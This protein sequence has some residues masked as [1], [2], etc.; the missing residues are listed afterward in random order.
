M[1]NRHPAATPGPPAGLRDLLRPN[2]FSTALLEKDRQ[3]DFWRELLSPLVDVTP[4]KPA[5]NGFKASGRSFDL[6]VVQVAAVKSEPMRFARSGAHAH[7]A[8]KY[9]CL[10]VLK[11]GT[12][13]N[14]VG[15]VR[16]EV[17]P[18]KI[19]IN[20]L[21]GAF[22]GR[23][24]RIECINLLL[25]RDFFFDME[26][27]ID[28]LINVRL[29]GPAARILSEFVLTSEKFFPALTISE[30][31]LWI[32][33]FSLLLGAVLRQQRD[34]RSSVPVSRDRASSVLDYIRENLHSQTLGARSICQALKI[35]RRQLYYLL[36]PYGGVAGLITR[37]RLV[38]VCRAL[39]RSSEC[40]L[41]STVAYSL[42]FS[43]YAV[44]CKQFRE[45]FGF[46]P[47]D[48]RDASICGYLPKKT[49]P[50]SLSQLLSDGTERQ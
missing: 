48:A 22:S 37:K 36:A 41:I 38:A 35:S 2:R 21:A 7:P 15:D 30:T 39:A 17:V 16:V 31:S 1:S 18:G 14:R 23:T 29:E 34:T 32:E 26:A 19:L 13:V 46:S 3:F 27:D 45:E 43:D 24:D 28:T 40:R 10:T 25:N 33:T 49:P 8:A 5:P 12:M 50:N 47:S 6:G 9:W 42:G 4:V 11:Q 44:F 20:S